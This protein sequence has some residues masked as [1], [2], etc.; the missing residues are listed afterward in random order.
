[1]LPMGTI[2]V[3]LKEQ[4]YLRA[5][6]AVAM[7]SRRL[8]AVVVAVS[9]LLLAATLSRWR[10]GLTREAIVWPFVWF[11]AVIGATLVHFVTTHVRARRI[12]GQ[13]RGLN[14][15]FTID[16]DDAGIQISSAQGSVRAPWS[17]FHKAWEIKDQFLLFTS[18][19]MFVMVPTRAFENDADLEAFR[20]L[21]SQR[22]RK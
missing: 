10:T 12:F 8:V 20:I 17:D 13:Q 3:Q 16:W 1:M 5:V 14:R 21:V 7:P 6:R 19:A 22:I 4:D 11:G 15:P 9:V 18:D 2:S